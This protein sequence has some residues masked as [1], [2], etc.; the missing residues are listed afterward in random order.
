MFSKSTTGQ[1]FFCI[2]VC[3]TGILSAADINLNATVDKNTVG[4][5]DR[6]VYTIEVSGQ[7]TN[8]PKPVFPSFE[9][10]SLI[11]GPNTSTNIQFING[12]MSASNTYSFYLLPQKEGKFSIPAA[13][14]SVDDEI[15]SSNEIQITVV[16]STSKKYSR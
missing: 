7:S 10:F 15:I 12:A 14:L 9:N 16:K 5:G 2:L 4:V 8:L 1:L 3:F 13:T 11:S 6:F